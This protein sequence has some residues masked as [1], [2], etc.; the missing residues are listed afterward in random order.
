[1]KIPMTIAFA[2]LTAISFSQSEKRLSY[3]SCDRDTLVLPDNE[4]GMRIFSAWAGAK[5][6]KPVILFA[7][8]SSIARM[9]KLMRIGSPIIREDAVVSESNGKY[10]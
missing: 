7:P 5:E 10:E 1:M 8:E 3:I 6:D 9:N 4:L 2:L